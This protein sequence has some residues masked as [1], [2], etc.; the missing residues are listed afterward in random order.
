M[1]AELNE[2]IAK[3]VLRHPPPWGWLDI[4]VIVDPNGNEVVA[5]ADQGL[6]E[7]IC[8]AVNALAIPM[9]TPI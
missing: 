9:L 7:L 8:E 5:V 2:L 1:N 4:G 6:G 3:A